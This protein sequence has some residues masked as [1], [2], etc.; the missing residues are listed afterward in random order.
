MAHMLLMTLAAFHS[1]SETARRADTRPLTA[2][3]PWHAN[4]EPSPPPFP[5]HAPGASAPARRAYN[6]RP[7]LAAPPSMLNKFLH[8]HPLTIPLATHHSFCCGGWRLRNVTSPSWNLSE[9]VQG[10]PGFLSSEVGAAAFFAVSAEEVH[11]HALLGLVQLSHLKSYEHVG[12][13]RVRVST[14]S[15]AD[16]PDLPGLCVSSD[17]NRPCYG[18]ERTP[19]S[20]PLLRR[21]SQL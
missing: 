13:M 21:R 17:P 18:C 4:T 8:S 11:E 10:K 7:P 5:P 12:A 16:A 3:P 14:F 1:A 6:P 19:T 2:P 15:R 20:P 9:D